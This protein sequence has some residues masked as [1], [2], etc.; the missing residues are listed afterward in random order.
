M[1]K[2]MREIYH[3]PENSNLGRVEVPWIVSAS[4]RSSSVELRGTEVT[5]RHLI[6]SSLKLQAATSDKGKQWLSSIRS[7]IISDSHD[8]MP[9]SLVAIL[10]PVHVLAYSTL[11]GTEL[12]QSFVMTKVAY[13]ALPRSAFTTLQKRIFPIYFQSQSLLLL[14]VVATCPPCGPMS[15]LKNRS[16]GISLMIA[17]STAVLNL[18]VYG[19]RTK[20]LMIERVHQ[21]M[22][23]ATLKTKRCCFADPLSYARRKTAAGR[24]CRNCERRDE[25]A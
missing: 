8:I 2:Y 7:S 13:Q 16:E 25:S 21:G 17:S 1:Q 6:R 15:L 10:A 22:Y 5:L 3:T 12:W 14:L 11:L 24:S 19:P 20:D 4:E 18:L 23:Y 9:Y